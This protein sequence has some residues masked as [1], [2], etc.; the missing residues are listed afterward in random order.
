MTNLTYI[1]TVLNPYMDTIATERHK[2][3]AAFKQPGDADMF[4]EMVERGITRKLAGD[5]TYEIVERTVEE[6]ELGTTVPDLGTPGVKHDS[7][8]PRPSLLIMSLANAVTEVSRV[9]SYGANKYSDDNWALVPNAVER[10]Q[11]ALLRHVLAEGTGEALDPESGLLH[12]AHVAAN[13]L[14]RLELQLRKANADTPSS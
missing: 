5:R 9:L 11:D 6:P 13:A 7:D 8:K 3:P 14:I 2:D 10:Y 1:L 12:T 4:A